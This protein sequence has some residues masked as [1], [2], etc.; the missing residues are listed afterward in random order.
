[1]KIRIQEL[2]CILANA[3]IKQ[4]VKLYLVG[5]KLKNN[6]LILSWIISHFSGSE[7]TKMYSRMQPYCLDCFFS[8]GRTHHFAQ[9]D[10]KE[11]G[12][13]AEDKLCSLAFYIK[14]GGRPFLFL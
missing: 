8:S 10:I 9:A 12:S 5:R 11:N 7:I 1:M 4:L 13:E 2:S 14:D 6:I 3:L